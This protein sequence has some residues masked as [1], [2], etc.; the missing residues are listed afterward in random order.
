MKFP[1]LFSKDDAVEE[2][3]SYVAPLPDTRTLDERVSYVPRRS[4]VDGRPR[5]ASERMSMFSSGLSEAIMAMQLQR[6][7]LVEQGMSSNNFLLGVA[8]TIITT[9][10]IGAFPQ[11][12]WT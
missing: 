2:E 12:F 6:T 3:E 9:Y 8:N 10:I 11:H 4:T 5:M 7:E 1:K